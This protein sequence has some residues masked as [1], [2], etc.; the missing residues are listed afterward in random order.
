MKKPFDYDPQQ[1]ICK[2]NVSHRA[3]AGADNAPG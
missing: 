3:F 1:I 2:V